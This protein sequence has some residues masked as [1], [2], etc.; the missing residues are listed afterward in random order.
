VGRV[1]IAGECR[2]VVFV[3]WEYPDFE[4]IDTGSE[5]TAYIFQD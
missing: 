3:M 5:I 2:E 4:I 1:I